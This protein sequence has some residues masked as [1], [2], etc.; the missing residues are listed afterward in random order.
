[1]EMAKR[2]LF[3]NGKLGAFLRVLVLFVIFTAPF[4]YHYGVTFVLGR[5]MYPSFECSEMVIVDKNNNDYQIKRYDVVEIQME[6]EK[7]IKRI[8]GLPGDYIKYGAGRVWVNGKRNHLFEYLDLNEVPKNSVITI[9]I[10]VPKGMV[11]VIGDNRNNSACSLIY[12]DQIT[13]KV[14]Y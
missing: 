10:I 8:V 1:M 2:L 9:D 12:V 14:L 7:W 13:G 11:W 4:F 6:E 3:G 5:S